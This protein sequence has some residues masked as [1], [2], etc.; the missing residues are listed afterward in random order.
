[1]GNLGFSG[2]AQTGYTAN[3]Q[4]GSS[5]SQ[6]GSL[7]GDNARRRTPVF[8]WHM[9]NVVALRRLLLLGSL[10]AVAALL[11]GCSSAPPLGSGSGA[12]V[13]APAPQVGKPV[14]MGLFDL[15]NQGT[16]PVTVR[17]VSLPDAR[18]MAMTAAWLVPANA[19]GPQLGVGQ[20]Y[21]PVTYPLWA[22]RVPAVGAV[23]RPGQDLQLVFGVLR[24]TAADGRS[25]QPMIV[26]TAGR[27]A[28]TLRE[29]GSLALSHTKCT[30]SF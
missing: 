11:A 1:V 4:I 12:G 27:A 28:Y 20:P 25:D 23:I 22:D 7:C 18:G 9:R 26:Y 6:N 17:S 3:A 19:S 5:F 21:P 10:S 29:Q 14:D 30:L 13:C 8:T 16:A 15:K 2:S 24:T